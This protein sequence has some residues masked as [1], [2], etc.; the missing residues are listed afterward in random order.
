[1]I[2]PVPRIKQWFKLGP[3]SLRNKKVYSCFVLAMAASPMR[4]SEPS[5]VSTPAPPPRVTYVVR[6]DPHTGRLVRTVVQAFT[7]PAKPRA[8][9]KVSPAVAAI[10]RESAKANQVDPLLVGSVIEVESNY[11]QYAV[12]PKGAEGL[13]QL[14]P[15]TARMLGVK[16]S[17]DAKENI[18]AGVR[19]LKTLQQ[20][21]K[22][23]RL[24]L[25]AYNAGP[26]A[27][28]KYKWVPPFPETRKYVDE[29]GRRY[30]EARAAEAVKAPAA[31]PSPEPAMPGLAASKSE[32]RH[33][34]LEQFIDPDGRL[35]LRTIN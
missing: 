5:S 11:D 6:A 9:S 14:M 33:P 10:V 4:A 22:D 8:A 35:H 34:R 19:Y 3:V 24:A 16:N 32:D 17:F 26:G 20:Q 15:Q 28:D 23:D 25:A 30:E 7:S 27:V 12:S 31:P 29:V 1:M 13:M 21:Y 2:V 18:E